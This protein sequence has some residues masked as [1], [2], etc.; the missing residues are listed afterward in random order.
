MYGCLIRLLAVFT[1]GLSSM[2]AL[3]L[4][5]NSY[6]IL[7]VIASTEKRSGVALVKDKSTGHTFAV[8]EGDGVDKQ[9]SAIL[10]AVNRK[11]V[12]IS[13]AGKPYRF[14]VGDEISSSASGSMIAPGASLAAAIEAEDGVVK[15]SASYKDHLI[16]DK[17]ATILMQ[18]AAV[19]YYQNNKLAGFTFWDIEKESVF[20]QIGL[21][22]GDTVTGINSQEI[23][24]VASTIK[25]LNSIKENA[26]EV[27]FTYLRAGVEH[28]TKIVID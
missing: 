12:D 16:K 9:K 3:A 1:I 11:F 2:N 5:N 20:E 19:P 15:V 22:D 17:L 18:A 27:Q 28:N 8:R 25:L 23:N 6:L 10:I 13:I 21:K 14:A 24:D 4:T 26:K 7:G